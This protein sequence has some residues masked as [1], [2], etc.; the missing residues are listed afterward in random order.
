MVQGGACAHTSKGHTILPPSLVILWISQGGK[1]NWLPL[2]FGYHDVMHTAPIL[3]LTGVVLNGSSCRAGLIEIL[4][5]CGL[6]LI[7]LLLVVCTFGSLHIF[8][9]HACW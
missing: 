5:S 3:A 1:P 6:K 9:F 2:N 8:R 7:F 4:R